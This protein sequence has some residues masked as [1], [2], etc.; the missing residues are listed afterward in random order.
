MCIDC[1]TVALGVHF[2][3]PTSS[4]TA[5]PLIR[6]EYLVDRLG[7]KM[8][9]FLGPGMVK[10][11]S[12]ESDRSLPAFHATL[13]YHPRRHNGRFPRTAWEEDFRSLLLE[14]TRKM[15]DLLAFKLFGED[16]YLLRQIA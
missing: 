3:A 5:F 11:L 7:E 13:Q 6:A 16:T 1:D 15:S 9:R 4:D 12:Q 2:Q 10:D 8:E 14:E